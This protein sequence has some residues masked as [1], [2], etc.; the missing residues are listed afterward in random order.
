MRIVVTIRTD[1]NT[2]KQAQRLFERLGIDMSTAINLFLKQSI[3]YQGLPFKVALDK[4]DALNETEETFSKNL[5]N[6]PKEL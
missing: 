5:F 1:E 2:K 6:P 4:K 3:R